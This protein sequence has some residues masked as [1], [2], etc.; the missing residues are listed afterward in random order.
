MTTWQRTVAVV[1]VLVLVVGV[2]GVVWWKQAEDRHRRACLADRVSSQLVES[3]TGH[4][5]NRRSNCD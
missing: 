3:W 1:A 2:A 4:E 5:S